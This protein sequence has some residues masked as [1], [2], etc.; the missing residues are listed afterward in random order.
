MNGLCIPA[1]ACV[2]Q[3]QLSPVLITDNEFLSGSLY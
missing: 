1:G 2:S 3:K